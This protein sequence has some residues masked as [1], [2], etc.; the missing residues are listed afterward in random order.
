MH[1]YPPLPPYLRGVPSRVCDRKPAK[2]TG[3]AR[4]RCSAAAAAAA[5][6][7]DQAAE[8]CLEEGEGGPGG[9][10]GH[11]KARWEAGPEGRGHGPAGAAS[12]GGGGGGGAEFGREREDGGE[13]AT[14]GVLHAG[15][16]AVEEVLGRERGREGQRERERDRETERQRETERDRERER[17]R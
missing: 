5:D 6:C 14:P 2:E 4:R 16:D 11:P 10:G 13:A 17:E 3:H 7:R 12:A 9:G 1:R 8:R 15:P